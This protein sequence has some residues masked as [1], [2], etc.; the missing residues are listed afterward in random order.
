M[1][2][3]SMIGG[4]V[5][6]LALAGYGAWCAYKR[7]YPNAANKMAKDMKHMTKNVENSIENMM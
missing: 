4:T 2:K 3:S 6:G 5:L 7:Y 1:K